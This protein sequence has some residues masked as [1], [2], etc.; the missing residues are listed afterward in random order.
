VTD[1]SNEPNLAVEQTIALLSRVF[2]II[3][4]AFGTALIT[5]FSVLP[6][7]ARKPEMVDLYV[8]MSRFA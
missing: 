7:A 4:I 8:M 2:L 1:T 6:N 5:C 3:A